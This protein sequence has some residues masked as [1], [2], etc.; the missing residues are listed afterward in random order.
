MARLHVLG[1]SGAGTTTL[2]AALANRLGYPHVDAD[3]LF[4]LPTDPPFTKKRP[5]D[6][7]QAMLL[8]LLPAAGQ[9]VFS[10]SAPEWARPIEPSYDL[11][12]F[13]WLDPAARMERLR[14]REAVRYGKR[15]EA[16]GDMAVASADFLKW[17]EA[18]DTAGPEQ[19]SL[20]GHAA[21]L[22]TLKA[23]VLRL[24]SAVALKDLVSAV[25][26]RLESRQ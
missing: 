23:P 21:W 22:A 10:G 13:L 25:L 26:S 19:R 5:R 2:G 6:K 18:Y 1:A 15:I 8:R 12:V 11:V 4:W 24:D 3:S 9:W 17:A 20:I 7:R 16:G 14:R